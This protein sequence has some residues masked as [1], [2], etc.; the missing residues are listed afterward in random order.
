MAQPLHMEVFM[1][2]REKIV[3]FDLYCDVCKFADKE[4]K[5]DP[6]DRC[7][8]ECTNT[9]SVLPVNFKPKNEK[10]KG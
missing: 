5:D 6:C 7:L 1:E 4:E 2:I 3:R 8:A 10:R 9:N